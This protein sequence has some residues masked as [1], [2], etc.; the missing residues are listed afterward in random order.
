MKYTVTALILLLVIG[1]RCST[2]Q[3]GNYEEGNHKDYHQ[4]GLDISNI[5]QS[6]LLKNVSTQ[7]KKNGIDSA[8]LFC[9]INASPLIDS[10][11]KENNVKISRVSEKNRNP[12]NTLS[13]DEKKLWK[14][15]ESTW[16]NKMDTVIDLHNGITYYK[17]ISIGMPTC[18]KCHGQT[19]EIGVNTL[20]L[21]RELYPKDKAIS[22]QLNDLRGFW[23]VE[24]MK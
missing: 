6:V 20:G 21:I 7:I 4:I 9:N 11:S 23:K 22:Y 1:L 12:E 17:P 24:F 8:I 5:S 14:F 19:K 2:S 3:S 10:L 15:Y 16:P 13:E 18:L